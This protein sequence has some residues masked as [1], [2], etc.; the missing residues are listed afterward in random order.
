MISV[1]FEVYFVVHSVELIDSLKCG[2]WDSSKHNS[3]QREISW[4]G[5][6][7]KQFNSFIKCMH[8]AIKH[9]AHLR[10]TPGTRK[11]SNDLLDQ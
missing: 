6:M 5:Q 4:Q 10:Q 2:R 7:E 1:R 9:P 3:D 11:L 8:A